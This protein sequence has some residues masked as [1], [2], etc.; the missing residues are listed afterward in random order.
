MRCIFPGK[1]SGKVEEVKVTK[2]YN[3]WRRD[4]W[5]DL[6]CEGCGATETVKDAYDDTNYWVNVVPDMK[7]KSCGKSSNDLGIRPESIGTK[8]PEGMEV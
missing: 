4:L 5:V 3:Q 1:P 8:Y 2:R 7:C 6:E